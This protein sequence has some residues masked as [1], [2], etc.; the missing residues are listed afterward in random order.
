[1][2]QGVRHGHETLL[3]WQL[4]SVFFLKA[5]KKRKRSAVN[6]QP[7]FHKTQEKMNESLGSI[8]RANEKEK[9]EESRK[10]Q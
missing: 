4:L 8:S 1:M 3:P 7:R 2:W 10:P 6:L 5:E 9:T